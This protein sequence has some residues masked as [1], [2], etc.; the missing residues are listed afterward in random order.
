[1][2][3]Y[4]KLFQSGI[5]SGEKLACPLGHSVGVC[6][7]GGGLSGAEVMGG[8]EEP[9]WSQEPRIHTIGGDRREEKELMKASDICLHN[10][11]LGHAFPPFLYFK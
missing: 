6:G 5:D 8:T 3:T 10:S 11:V 4:Q 7:A 9:H 1:M 2:V